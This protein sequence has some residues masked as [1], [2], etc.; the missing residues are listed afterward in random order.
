MKPVLVKRS[1]KVNAE[2]ERKQ[3]KKEA[4]IARALQAQ[5]KQKSKRKPRQGRAAPTK[6]AR[7][8]VLV[9]DSSDE[10]A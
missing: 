7:P 10:G 1:D 2:L 9:S 3:A 5:Q 8:L 4:K 6:R